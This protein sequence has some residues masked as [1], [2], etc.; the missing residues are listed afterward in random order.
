MVSF[1]RKL[2]TSSV[3]SMET[4][5][6]FSS[7]YEYSFAVVYNGPPL[8]HS[9]PEIPTFMID[10][11]PVASIAPSL[12]HDFNVPVIQPLGKLHHKVKHKHKKTTSDST[13]YPNLESHH[14]VEVVTSKVDFNENQNVVDDVPTN[15]DTIE[16]GSGSR[17]GF[18]SPSCEICSVSEDEEVV[19]RAKHVKNPSAVTFRDPE[20]NDMIQTES[21][22]YFDSESVQLKPH[23]IRPGKKGSCYKCL[24]GNGLTEK[25]VCI[26]CSA[27][28]CRN[29]VIRA[30]GSMPEGRKCVGCI[31]YG[32]DENK[33]RNLGKCSRMMKQ[34]LSETIV[35]QVMK[36]ERFCEANQIP[37]RL[38]RVNLNPLNREEL[39]VLLNC[40]NPPKELK[41]GSY[42]YDKASGFWG[43]VKNQNST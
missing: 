12:S 41:P 4:E 34:L 6:S 24:K 35:D 40:K 19:V 39:M 5:D 26:V 1:M 17:S 42:W 36:D 33:R 23:A 38:V 14:V 9:I 3:P 10:Q 30:M 20:S 29:C 31:G 15:S 43:K 28:Y 8:D 25:E 2:R 27:K 7:N 13:V 22:E 16:S 37:P 21:D 11:I 18:S 32:I